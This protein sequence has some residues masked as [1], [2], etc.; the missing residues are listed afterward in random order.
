M[1][2]N[3]ENPGNVFLVRESRGINI[4]IGI[5]LALMSASSFAYMKDNFFSAFIALS[6]A[7][8]ITMGI[9]KK[10]VLQ[11]DQSGIYYY[12]DLLTNWENFMKAH[13]QEESYSTGETMNTAYFLYVEYFVASANSVCVSR[14]M[15]KNTLDKSEE[16][17]I[18]AIEKYYK[19]YSDHV[20]HV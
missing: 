15:M 19:D 5:S 2:G 3:K 13:Y 9:Q 6:A 4:F 20:S 10:I 1:T 12:A 8:C 7:L 17:I 14:I 11:I 18:A 16:S